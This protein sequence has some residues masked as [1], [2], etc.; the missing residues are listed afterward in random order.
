MSYYRLSCEAIRVRILK[1]FPNAV[2]KQCE[3]KAVPK[4]A[5]PEHLFWMISEVSSWDTSSIKHATKAGRW[6]GWMYRAMEELGLLDNEGSRI[7]AKKDMNAGY[8]LPHR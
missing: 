1:S 7:V 6:I 5:L 3:R 2:A 8:H 4:E